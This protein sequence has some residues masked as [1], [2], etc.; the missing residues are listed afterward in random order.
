MPRPIVSKSSTVWRG[1]LLDGSGT[2]SLDSSEAASLPLSWKVRAEEHSQGTTSPEELIGAAHSACY[3][4]ALTN[5]LA[6]NGTPASDVNTGADVT[7][8]VDKGI[9]SI[10]LVTVAR[11]EGIDADQFRALAERAKKECPVSKALKGTSITLSAD[12]A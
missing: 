7:F 2:V 5:L 8:E 9:T 11:V 1:S 4:M 3:S 6:E 12:L 10:N